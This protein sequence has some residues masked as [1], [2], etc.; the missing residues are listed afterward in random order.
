MSEGN[1]TDGETF[2]ISFSRQETV[3]A[4]QRRPRCGIFRGCPV[5]SSH[6]FP[7]PAPHVGHEIADICFAETLM[8]LIV[9]GIVT[10]V[11]HQE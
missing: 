5:L 11:A 8:L 1:V 7:G 10:K 4:C 6:F 2:R 3:R 9:A